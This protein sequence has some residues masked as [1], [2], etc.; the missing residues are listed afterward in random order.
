MQISSHTRSHVTG[1]DIHNAIHFHS[2]VPSITNLNIPL[3][4]HNIFFIVHIAIYF[5]SF[6]SP[7]TH[8]Q[9]YIIH[10][11]FHTTPHHTTIN[12]TESVHL[13]VYKITYHNMA[14]ATHIVFI[15]NNVNN[16]N[17]QSAFVNTSLLE[18]ICAN[19]THHT[20]CNWWRYT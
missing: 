10:N 18:P 3:P 11:I 17:T 9:I 7:T 20:I 6:V 13:T 14:C 2:I 19:F 12:Q 4:V 8:I 5:H 16:F 1:G 15:E